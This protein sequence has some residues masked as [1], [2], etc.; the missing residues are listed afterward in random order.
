[1][2]GTKQFS[3]KKE[4][5]MTKSTSDVISLTAG[6]NKNQCLLQAHASNR[7]K[8]F[9]HKKVA[10]LLSFLLKWGFD[11]DKLNSVSVAEDDAIKGPNYDGWTKLKILIDRKMFR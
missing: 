2:L 8:L 7:Y 9:T 10:I 5:Y 6:A 3:G 11:G 1:M 4:N